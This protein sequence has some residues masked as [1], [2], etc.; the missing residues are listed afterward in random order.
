MFLISSSR[1]RR[2]A[3][4]KI[5]F[6]QNRNRIAPI[7]QPASEKKAIQIQTNNKKHTASL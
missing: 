3:K 6:W 4:E 2:E 1:F 5:V 7:Q